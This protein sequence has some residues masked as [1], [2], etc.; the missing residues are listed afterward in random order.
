MLLSCCVHVAI[1]N[2]VVV[3]ATRCVLVVVVFVVAQIPNVA[4]M[5]LSC[6]F[7]VAVALL[8]MCVH[9]VFMLLSCCVLVCFHAAHRNLGGGQRG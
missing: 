3:I 9:V 5:L 7:H 4:F 6:Y 2:P 1:G 8:S